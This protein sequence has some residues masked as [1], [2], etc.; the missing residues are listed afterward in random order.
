MDDATPQPTEETPKETPGALDDDELPPFDLPEPLP[1]VKAPAGIPETLALTETFPTA[2]P[3]AAE[4]D[5]LLTEEELPDPEPPEPDIEVAF[6]PADVPEESVDWPA[7]IP[8][9]AKA[10]MAMVQE[11]RVNLVWI[12][13]WKIIFASFIWVWPSGERGQRHHRVRQETSLLIPLAT[14]RW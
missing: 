7:A 6:A 5:A 14:Q 1:L 4:T 3:A 12:A 9:Q 13:N 10:K 11:A 8:A 2:D